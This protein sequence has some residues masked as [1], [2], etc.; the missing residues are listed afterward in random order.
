MD[1]DLKQ[2]KKIALSSNDDKTCKFLIKLHHIHMAKSAGK[3]Y[4]TELLK[5]VF[6]TK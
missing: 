2:I 4:K 1:T 6:D 3:V 5:K